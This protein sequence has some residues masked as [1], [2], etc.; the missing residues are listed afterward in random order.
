LVVIDRGHPRIADQAGVVR[1]EHCPPVEV[2]TTALV[3]TPAARA[4]AKASQR[5]VYGDYRMV[6][7]LGRRNAHESTAQ[8]AAEIVMRT[9]TW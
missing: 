2:N 5:Y 3:S 8:L 6:E 4:I 1:D 9:S 7:L